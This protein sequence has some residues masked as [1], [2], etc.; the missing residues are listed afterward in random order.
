MNNI[1]AMFKMLLDSNRPRYLLNYVFMARQYGKRY[2]QQMFL[3]YYY[4]PGWA[5]QEPVMSKFGQYIR[6]MQN[7]LRKENKWT[8]NHVPNAMG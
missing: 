8:H 2:F 4:F 1:D 3:D 7:S 6:I 5:D